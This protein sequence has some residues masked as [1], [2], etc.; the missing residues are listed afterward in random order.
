MRW[1]LALSMLVA[2]SGPGG[3]E[4]RAGGEC[5]CPDG[6]TGVLQCAPEGAACICT[7][8]PDASPPD[9]GVDAGQ[10]SGP[11][12]A[13]ELIDTIVP[14][15]DSGE[16]DAGTPDATV[17][18]LVTQE[19]CPG[20]TQCQRSRLD[21]GPSNLNT[22][23]PECARPGSLLSGGSP[24]WVF[25]PDRRDDCFRGYFCATYS[26]CVKHCRTDDDCEGEPE[27]VYCRSDPAFQNGFPHCAIDTR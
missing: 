4:C 20:G 21:G 8:T 26:E 19:G 1:I 16:P 2:C 14:E 23:P 3:D 12:D 25:D 15:P 11:S 18:D 5:T 9:S 27:P 13:G 7:L 10:D 24:C 22:G 17:C 6:S